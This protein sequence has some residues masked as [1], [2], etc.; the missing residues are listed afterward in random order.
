MRPNPR[1]NL[2]KPRAQAF[3]AQVGRCYYC[4]PPMRQTHSKQFA[5]QH[6]LT[7]K[8]ITRLQCTGEHLA[9]HKI[10]GGAGG[11]NIMAACR[12]FNQTRHRRPVD[13]SPDEFKRLV[14]KRMKR[15]GWHS[16]GLHRRKV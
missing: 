6:G 4:H 12:F 7:M 11:G 14:E 13:L 15:R 2:A 16:E 8:P 1:K 3:Q 5:A 10:G 9:S